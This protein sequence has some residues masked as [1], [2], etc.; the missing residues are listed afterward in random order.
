M[1]IYKI[2]GDTIIFKE[3]LINE[4]ITAT[5]VRLI[6][7]SG[8]QLGV[9]PKAD[10]MQEA[11]NAGLDLVQMSFGGGIAVCKILDYGKYKFDTIKKEKELKKNQ[12]VT[13]VKEVQLSMT[14]DTRDLEI[15][16]KRGYEFLSD[17]NKL[18]VVLRMSGR[19]Q[20][21][22]KKAVEVVKSYCEMVAEKGTPD[23]EPEIVGRNII[24]IVSPK[25]AK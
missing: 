15:K 8:E 21:Y 13:E 12:K 2:K 1:D 6:G 17:G 11:E 5:Q 22:A 24:V 4:Q 3:L 25:K 20:A 23:K 18:K 16:A 7:A 14:I 19:Q 9:M 10:A